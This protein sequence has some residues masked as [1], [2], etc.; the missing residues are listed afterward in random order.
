MKDHELTP[1]QKRNRAKPPRPEGRPSS[2]RKQYN[3]IVFGFALAG[4]TEKEMA[5]HFGVSEQTF[6]AWKNK[7]PK[8]LES[9]KAGKAPAN[10]QTVNSIFKMA[11]GYERIEEEVR[12]DAD[13][14]PTVIHVKKYYPP[15]PTAAIFFAKNRMP[16]KWRDKHEQVLTDPN[17]AGAFDVL[18][19]EIAKQIVKQT[20][21]S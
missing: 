7:H 4:Y 17:G 11:N 19:V 21:T 13:G 10:G 1:R 5:G 16:D 20:P 15:V 6:N 8:F 9:L 14:N 18:A 3:T 12:T 2:Y